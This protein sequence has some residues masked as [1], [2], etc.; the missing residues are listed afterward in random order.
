MNKE[1]DLSE[2]YSSLKVLYDD[3]KRVCINKQVIISFN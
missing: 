1:P 2:A 3:L